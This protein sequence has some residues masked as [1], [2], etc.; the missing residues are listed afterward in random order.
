MELVELISPLP[1]GAGRIGLLSSDEFLPRTRPFDAAL[2]EGIE[3]RRIGVILCAHHPSASQGL[4]FA[5]RAWPDR[6]VI[7]VCASCAPD[8]PIPEVDLLFLA[9]GDPKALLECIRARDG[10]WP[11]VL[12]RWRAGMPLAGSSAGAMVLCEHAIGTCPCLDPTHEWGDGLGPVSGIG[13][14]VHA[15]VREPAWLAHLPSV[16][17]SAVVAMD[18]A[19]AIILDPGQAPR[20]FGRVRVL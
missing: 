20:T 18:E 6:Q 12:K 7:Q 17:P 8:E 16:A 14:A 10:F 5:Q 2:F 13:L 15:D 1:E 3:P 4:A 9:G 19:A 11:E